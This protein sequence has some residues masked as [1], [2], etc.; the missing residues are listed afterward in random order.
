MNA[1]ALTCL[2]LVALA[3]AVIGA[4]PGLILWWIG[5]LL[6]CV[7]RRPDTRGLRERALLVSQMPNRVPSLSARARA[8]RMA[9]L[10]A[11]GAAA[12]AGSPPVNQV[13][14][15]EAPVLGPEDL[16]LVKNGFEAAARTS[17]QAVVYEH[18]AHQIASWFQIMNFLSLGVA[19]GFILL[20]TV[21]DVEWLRTAA[22]ILSGT[23]SLGAWVW[24]AFSYA[25]HWETQRDS[26]DDVA[27]RARRLSKAL[28]RAVVA[29]QSSSGTR[30]D[31]MR[32]SLDSLLAQADDLYSDI[33]K[34]KISYAPEF[35]V[36]AQQ[37]T[38]R[39]LGV[40]CG[41]CRQSW[42]G[43]GTLIF[44]RLAEVRRFFK[45]HKQ[46]FDAGKRCPRCAQPC[47]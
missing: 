15:A 18:R 14:S 38:M 37:A 41:Q 19:P 42:S 47:S 28:H 35:E 12:E 31:L 27:N 8:A 7:A 46:E 23:C 6:I 36:L 16:A 13:P 29:L 20:I 24:T 21:K 26:S 17:H 45:A 1:V 33:E 30:R 5:R 44:A 32:T 2:M 40:S 22:L 3:G 4:L 25:F 43:S 11:A 39:Q 34:A 10:P 9:G